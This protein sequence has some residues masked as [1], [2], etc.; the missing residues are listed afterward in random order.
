[1]MC[2]R[3]PVRELTPLAKAALRRLRLVQ[4]AERADQ[5]QA[6]ADAR[7]RQEYRARWLSRQWH[8]HRHLFTVE[9]ADVPRGKA[10][11]PRDPLADEFDAYLWHDQRRHAAPRGTTLVATVAGIVIVVIAAWL[12][13]VASCGGQVG[14]HP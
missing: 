12:L 2:R 11:T 5:Y 14:C 13:Y 7:D 8:A 4:S 3:Q 9:R 1:M 6:V 10:A